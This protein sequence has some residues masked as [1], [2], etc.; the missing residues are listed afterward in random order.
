MMPKEWSQSRFDS[1]AI[2]SQE[3]LSILKFGK[4]REEYF[5]K[6]KYWKESLKLSLEESGF[7]TKQGYE[8]LDK[9]ASYLIFLIKK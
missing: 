7:A 5:L 9:I 8:I 3:S 1:Q 2:F 4:R 6:H